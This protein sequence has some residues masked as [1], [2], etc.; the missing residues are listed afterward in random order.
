MVLREAL[1]PCKY[2]LFRPVDTLVCYTVGSTV[3]CS[4]TVL[5]ALPAKTSSEMRFD[6]V[7]VLL[8]SASSNVQSYAILK[9]QTRSAA[10]PYAPYSVSCPSTSLI[11][12]A[13]HLNRK[14]RSY[15]YRR[16]EKASRALRS[17]L[18]SIWGCEIALPWSSPGCPFQQPRNMPILAMALSGGGP[19]A[20]LAAAGVL[21]SLDARENSSSSIAGLLQSISYIS[22]L[23]GGSLTLSG[24]MAND[25]AKISTLKT[26]F[27]DRSYQNTFAAA[28]Q[29]TDVVVSKEPCNATLTKRS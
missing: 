15:I 24:V 20:G 3:H 25:F 1:D 13:Q 19:K 21:Y 26:E 5:F 14:E 18:A 4:S 9:S 12:Q 10:Q 17:W 23:S 28:Q 2:A 29:H 8:L 11:R 22:A 27:Y 7:A 16:E 6:L